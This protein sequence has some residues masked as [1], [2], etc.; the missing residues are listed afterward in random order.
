M[1]PFDDLIVDKT[2]PD[3]RKSKA[4]GG[5]EHQF[6]EAA[7]MLAVATHLLETEPTATRVEIHPDGE[8]AKQFKIK[9]WL[10]VTRCSSRDQFGFAISVP[11]S[12]QT[13]TNTLR[14][15]V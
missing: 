5:I 9:S 10:E 8:H 1:P 11:R 15:L 7:V 13:S 6:T 12:S 4:E 3:K 14:G 2:P